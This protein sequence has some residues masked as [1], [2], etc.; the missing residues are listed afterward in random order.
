VCGSGAVVSSWSLLIR[1]AQRA[2]CQAETPLIVSFRFLR[3]ALYTS[4][5]KREADFSLLHQISKVQVV[6]GAKLALLRERNHVRPCALD[7]D[8]HA[9]VE[10]RQ[11]ARGGMPAM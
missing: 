4:R 5:A 1:W 3:P 11:S 10:R 9:A 8:K 2:R 7:A 6:Q